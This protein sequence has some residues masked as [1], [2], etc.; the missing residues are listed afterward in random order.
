MASQ[1]H[2]ILVNDENDHSHGYQRLMRSVVPADL[3]TVHS[4]LSGAPNT[5]TAPGQIHSG[6]QYIHGFHYRHGTA[7][8]TFTPWC[9]SY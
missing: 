7:R 6:G 9:R 5:F 1:R 8:I 2:L 3:Q 4:D